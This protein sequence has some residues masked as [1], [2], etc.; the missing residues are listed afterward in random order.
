MWNMQIVKIST[1]N[2]VILSNFALR[3]WVFSNLKLKAKIEGSGE[4]VLQIYMD[5]TE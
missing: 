2:Q 5:K 4:S 3:I 1:L